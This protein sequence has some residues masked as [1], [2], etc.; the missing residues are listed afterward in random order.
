MT[1][2]L[3]SQFDTEDIAARDRYDA[4][5]DSIGTVFDVS[6]LRVEKANFRATLTG[7][8]LG[9]AMLGRCRTSA[10]R[11]ARGKEKIARDCMDHF[12]IQLFVRGGTQCV[13]S[14]ISATENHLIVIDT[15]KAWLAENPDFDLVT[16]SEGDSKS[17]R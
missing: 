13:D 5:K 14:E 9:E 3:K 1:S 17:K 12:M 11:F 15:S 7:Y 6:N 4:F 2:I 10:Q 8:L 16:L